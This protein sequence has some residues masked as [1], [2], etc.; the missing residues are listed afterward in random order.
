MFDKWIDFVF[1]HP[2]TDPSWFIKMD[3]K[4]LDE[5]EERY[6]NH[7]TLKYFTDLML[8]PIEVLDKFSNEQV[9]EGF[10][11]LFYS[12]GNRTYDQDYNPQPLLPHQERKECIEAMIHL[13]RSLYAKRCSEIFIDFDE[14][15]DNRLNWSCHMWW[16]LLRDENILLGE[17]GEDKDIGYV[18]IDVIDK[19]LEIE[20]VACQASA[21]HGLGHFME[22]YPDKVKPILDDYLSKPISQDDLRIYAEAALKVGKGGAWL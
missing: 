1:N 3:Y 16:D 17:M 8:D 21:I 11:F 9:D 13:F 2:V 4:E 5:L 18:C 19:I 12:F 10:W 20:H 22:F 6:D 15:V 7:I 14:D